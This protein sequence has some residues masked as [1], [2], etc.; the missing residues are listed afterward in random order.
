MKVNNEEIS[1]KL[2]NKLLNTVKDFHNYIANMN[3]EMSTC[4]VISAVVYQN[5]V[6]MNLYTDLIPRENADKYLIS[7]MDNFRRDLVSKTFKI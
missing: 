3:G 7:A 4:I 2:K 6:S 1:E 5:E